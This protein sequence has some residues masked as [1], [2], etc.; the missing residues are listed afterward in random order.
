V[1]FDAPAAPAVALADLLGSPNSWEAAWLAQRLAA[2]PSWHHDHLPLHSAAAVPEETEPADA[3]V[4]SLHESRHALPQAWAIVTDEATGLTISIERPG[5]ISDDLEPSLDTLW[6]SAL[7]IDRLAPVFEWLELTIALRVVAPRVWFA[8]GPR[9]AAALEL[10]LT[11]TRQARSAV[12]T[13][14]LQECTHLVRLVQACASLAQAQE[15]AMQASTVDAAH[16]HEGTGPERTP[17]DATPSQ[18]LRAFIVQSHASIAPGTLGALE[19]GDGLVLDRVGRRGQCGLWAPS[20]DCWLALGTVVPA[21]PGSW[22]LSDLGFD[23]LAHDAVVWPVVPDDAV[24]GHAH[25]AAAIG[26]V[27]LSATALAAMRPG[28]LV[29][30]T[31]T[32]DRQC[33]VASP[34]RRIGLA[35]MLRLGRHQVARL[36]WLQQ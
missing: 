7:V 14:A 22:Q 11:L 10:G 21:S 30:C 17:G 24:A 16:M 31:Q 4:F 35:H 9:R 34:G 32:S 13:V 12:F 19:V 28:D 8:G 29:K 1:S 15:D 3:L 6:L 33:W 2:A 23:P 36:G 18:T 25:V 5:W 26:V 20:G 27:G